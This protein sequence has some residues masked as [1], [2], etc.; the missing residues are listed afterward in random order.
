MVQ[1]FLSFLAATPTLASADQWLQTPRWS[2][3]DG[4][5]HQITQTSDAISGQPLAAQAPAICS[6]LKP[7][8]QAP[9]PTPI[10]ASDHDVTV[11]NDVAGSLPR[12]KM[13][14]IDR[15]PDGDPHPSGLTAIFC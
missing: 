5:C 4:E 9:C 8:E 2:Q 3:V 12:V 13:P 11:P 7:A 10:Y 15:Y 14:R 6:L 1:P